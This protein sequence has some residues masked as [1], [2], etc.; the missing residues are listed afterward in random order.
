MC[1]GS[2]DVWWLMVCACVLFFADLTYAGA[3]DY[4]YETC[5]GCYFAVSYH[6]LA[7]REKNRGGAG[8]VRV[9]GPA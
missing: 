2:P 8:P 1:V 5:S 9:G 7:G 3:Y 4:H 6:E